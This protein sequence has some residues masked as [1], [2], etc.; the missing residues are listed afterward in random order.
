MPAW[1][2]RT[3]LIALIGFFPTPA[4]GIGAIEYPDNMRQQ[5]AKKSLDYTCS[6]CGCHNRTALPAVTEQNNNENNVEQNN[7]VDNEQPSPAVLSNQQE[8]DSV[9]TNEQVN[10]AVTDNVNTSETTPVPTVSPSE[11][12]RRT[13]NTSVQQRRPY[14]APRKLST[15]A[16]SSAFEPG[17]LL[18]NMLI[19]AIAVLIGIIMFNKI[20]DRFKL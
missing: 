9:N 2:I 10:A 20:A 6:T 15:A 14:N 8:T 16:P 11:I 12:T 17:A 7:N 3:V 18:L 1:G 19:F 13:S 5:F 4:Q